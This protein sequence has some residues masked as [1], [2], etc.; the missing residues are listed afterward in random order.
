MRRREFWLLIMPSLIVMGGLLVIPLYRTI[1][2]SF[3]DVTYGTPGTFVGVDNYHEA[4]VDQRFHEAV[5]FTVGLT[6]TATLVIVVLA[7]I[8]AALINR[9]IRMRPVVLGIML[10]PYVIPHVVGAT[11]Y[12]WLFDSNF[13]GVVNVMIEALTGQ[14]IY[15]FIDVWPNRLLV[16]SNVVWSMLPF[17]MLM[18]IAGLQGVPEETIE[19]AQIDGANMWQRHV[20]VIIPSIRGVLGFVLLILIMDI[21]RVFD[22][23][24]PLAPNAVQIGNESIML[25]IYNIAFQEGAQQLGLGSAVNILTIIIILIMLWPSVRGVL[26]EASGK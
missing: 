19:A 2:W 7:Y 21:L 18:I 26:R 15:W 6:I 3:Q 11:A 8:L 17:A 24:I 22:N 10:I 25:Y 4:L 20:Y 13:G 23:L 14:E 9:L 5:I 1:T 12:S 16:M